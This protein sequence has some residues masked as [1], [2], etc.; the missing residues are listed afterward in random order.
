MEVWLYLG[1]TGPRGQHTR[2]RNS[3]RIYTRAPPKRVGRAFALLT[4]TYHGS[5]VL[6]RGHRAER[7]TH[8]AKKFKKNLHPRSSEA[9][10]ESFCPLDKDLS[11]KSRYRTLR[12]WRFGP[13]TRS[14]HIRVV[15]R[16]SES[17]RGDRCT[18]TV[19]K[20][21]LFD[22]LGLTL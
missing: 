5:L 17:I 21:Y 7:P 19:P 20:P 18:K 22:A 2:R 6:S 9:R 4:K 15:K 13:P 11:W 12:S 8:A 14:S 3:K 10:R 1:T 16:S